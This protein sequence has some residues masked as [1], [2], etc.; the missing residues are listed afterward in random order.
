MNDY[1]EFLQKKILVAP[2]T[3]FD[4]SPNELNPQLF[5]WQRQIVSWALA[6]G[7][8]ALF[9]DCGLG[10]TA[11]QLEWARRVAHH[12]GKPTLILTPLAVARQTAREAIKFK[13]DDAMPVHVFTDSDSICGT[14]PEIC[15]SNYE[16]LARFDCSLFGGVVLDESSILK[17]YDGKTR[18]AIIESFAQTPFKLACTATP[19][20][21]DHMELGNHAEF[22]GAMSRVE[23]LSRFF[24]HD[25]GETS[26]WRLKGHAQ[27]E[28]WKWVC[29]WGVMV[30]RPSDL[31][32]DDGDWE[33]PPLEIIEHR[34]AKETMSESRL[35][36][37]AACSLSE[38]RDAR[39][40]SL[41]ER[42]KGAAAQVSAWDE[43]CL[44]FCDFNAEGDAL[45]QSIDGAVQIAG[46]DDETFKA[47]A[48][49]RFADGEIQTLVTKPSIAGFGMNWQHCSKVV[50]CG[51]S[52]SFEQFYQAIR[53][54]WRF[55]QKRPVEVHIF[56]S[57][58]EMNV[59]E[60]IRRKQADADKMSDSM[61][62]YLRENGL[63]A[64][65][66]TARELMP[67]KRQTDTGQRW[68]AHLGDAV[69][70]VREMASDSIDYSIFSPPFASLY[71]YSNS[72]RDMGNCA[73]DAEFFEQFDF[74]I[75]DLYRVMKPGRLLSFHCMNMPT[76]KAR[77][78]VI[79][80]H[81]FRGELIRSFVEKGFIFHSEVC[82]WKDPVTQMQRTK[83]LG[84]LHKTI[85]KDSSM[86]RQGLADYL[87]TMRKPGE[88]ENP[89]R[90]FRDYQELVEFHRGKVITPESESQIFP[91]DMWQNYASPVWMDINPSRTLQKSSAR[92][93]NDERHICPLQLDVIERAIQLWT[94]P[95]DLVLSPFGGIGSEGFVA[96]EMG[97]RAVLC[98]LK[99]SYYRQMVANLYRAELS[100]TQ[101]SMFDEVDAD[102]AELMAA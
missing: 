62:Q 80:L 76:L 2:N 88:N 11:Q 65:G 49:M 57:D 22:L 71:T 9:E 34:V 10:K 87:V 27:D 28:F 36:P 66:A 52:D 89:I 25:G 70:I 5:D 73:G 60:N 94:N 47:D 95:G 55:G 39:R 75:R 63:D 37:V 77:D 1:N 91:V 48:M 56:I 3:G 85:R 51:L 23:M 58:A 16:K 30:R 64:S 97:R 24:V 33:L 86:S 19:A 15:I 53:R 78:G 18:T 96:V 98:E 81:D 59:V 69:E 8:C 6:K 4:L 42:V 45:A 84:L 41:E 29:S 72:E 68:T 13:I 92:E 12:T 17:S 43:P 82:I 54:C 14:E 90:H 40:A 32:C 7:R 26:K 67:Y 35:F 21:N 50:F 79:G 99:E 46:A 44:V 20:P 100:A 83:A 38:R 102:G 61:T 93:E 74:L 31:G 101:I